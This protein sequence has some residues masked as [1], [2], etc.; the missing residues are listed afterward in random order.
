MPKPQ[1]GLRG[2][3]YTESVTRYATGTERATRNLT[4][5][6]GNTTSSRNIERSAKATTLM[7]RVMKTA[8]GAFERNSITLKLF[9]KLIDIFMKFID[10]GILKTLMPYLTKLF[11]ILSDPDVQEA[12]MA[13][14]EVIVA[15]LVPYLALLII[16]LEALKPYLPELTSALHRM[17]EAL[18]I[19]SPYLAA[20]IL[21]FNSMNDTLVASGTQVTA[22]GTAIIILGDFFTG[23]AENG[24][25]VSG[26][27]DLLSVAFGSLN[28]NAEELHETL[29][30]LDARVTTVN[31]C[32]KG[33]I[34]V[35]EWL[36]GVIVLWHSNT[37]QL[38]VVIGKVNWL[39]LAMI[40]AFGGVGVII[41]SLTGTFEEMGVTLKNV[42]NI[43]KDFLEGISGWNSGGGGGGGGGGDGG[44][45]FPQL[46]LLPLPFP[47][48]QHGAYVDKPLIASTG[49]KSIIM[50]EAGG[51]HITPDYKLNRLFS[52]LKGEMSA[53]KMI[54]YQ[55]LKD[56]RTRVDWR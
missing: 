21:L 22:L 7:F 51:E 24:D 9:M 45:E 13:L 34:V 28:G 18:K 37:S 23:L 33:Y 25:M 47:L 48:L 1:G 40:V 27:I 29:G 5:Q 55:M 16:G 38:A 15:S 32:I 39:A 42:G 17:A 6:M 31:Y 35:L 43:I 26:S 11:E 50:G 19:G 36:V 14:G 54:L 12:L 46:P 8:M 44:F 2:I 3:S 4:F 30:F 10:I 56:S 53:V 20:W 52:E 49:R 41:L